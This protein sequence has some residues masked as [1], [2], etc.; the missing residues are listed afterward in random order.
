M[1]LSLIHIFQEVTNQANLILAGHSLGGL[2]RIPFLGGLIEKENV[3]NYEY[4]K[5]ESG[6]ATMYVSNG[7]GT[8]SYTHLD[9]YKR[10][11][12]TSFS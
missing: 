11:N 8:V 7:I 1:F 6:S 3:G 12:I 10:Q 2:I 4:G 9:V 5:Y